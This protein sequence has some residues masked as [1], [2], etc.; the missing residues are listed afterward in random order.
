MEAWRFPVLAQRAV[1]DSPRWTRAR[2]ETARPPLVNTRGGR[3]EGG[4]LGLR[5]H[6]EMNQVVIGK[7][8]PRSNPFCVGTISLFCSVP[9]PLL[10][11]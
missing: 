8:I 6:D 5:G 2:W 11:T 1:A 7:S 3:R 4:K 9:S 10:D